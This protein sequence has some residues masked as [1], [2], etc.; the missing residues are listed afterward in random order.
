MKLEG[1]RLKN[2]HTRY[3][4]AAQ[5]IPY[6]NPVILN[7]IRNQ[8]KKGYSPIILV[9]GQQR[10]GKTAL[11]LRLAYEINNDFN[12]Q[13]D[14]FFKIEDFAQA[15]SENTHKV[16]I[17]DEAGIELDP[18]EHMAIHQRVYSHIIQTQAY[19]NNVIFI[20]LPFASEIGKRHCKHVNAILE[21]FGRGCF[22]TYSAH[23]WRSDLSMRPPRLTHMETFVGM[24]LPPDNIWKPYIESG[25]KI[26]K[27]GIMSL[28]LD[29]L[30]M[31]KNK[32]NPSK[33]Q[34]ISVMAQAQ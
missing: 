5:Q 15:I 16:F 3:R 6:G 13:T 11:A 14:M 12:T 24:P 22:K 29:I 26:Y 28:Q 25:Q 33:K 1:M 27:E 23:S 9:V 19:K 32:I 34:K 17:L 31:R 10:S 20:V 8:I 2:N 21:V 18:Y 4:S 7:H 30:A